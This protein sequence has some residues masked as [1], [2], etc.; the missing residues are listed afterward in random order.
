MSIKVLMPFYL[1]TSLFFETSN[2]QKAAEPVII[3]TKVT[4]PYGTEAG[5]QLRSVQDHGGY[6]GALSRSLP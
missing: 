1:D 4:L 2:I 6:C 3:A 5:F